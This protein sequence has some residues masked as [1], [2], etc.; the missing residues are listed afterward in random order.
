MT[1]LRVRSAFTCS[2]AMPHVL[3][4]RS[5]CIVTLAASYF[6]WPPKVLSLAEAEAVLHTSALARSKFVMFDANL[7]RPH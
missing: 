7:Y 3:I 5:D 2:N 6:S 1:Q 4:R